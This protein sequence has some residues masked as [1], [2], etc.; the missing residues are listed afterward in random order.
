ML[1]HL[2]QSFPPIK[3]IRIFYFFINSNISETQQNRRLG[4]GSVFLLV[5]YFIVFYKTLIHLNI[6]F[7]TT[8]T[9]VY[10][11]RL[12]CFIFLITIETVLKA[13]ECT[14]SFRYI[15]HHLPL[16]ANFRF[17]GSI[18]CFMFRQLIILS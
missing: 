6:L 5:F 12:C 9:I 7:Y 13:H 18:Q 14:L 8:P 15:Y 4:V 2:I 1:S 17:A 10:Y 16:L 11:R 3:R